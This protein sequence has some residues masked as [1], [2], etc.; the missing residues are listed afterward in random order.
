MLQV[1]STEGPGLFWP[2]VRGAV[3]YPSQFS[4]WSL[5]LPYQQIQVDPHGLNADP[6]LPRP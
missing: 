4:V 6:E 1:K 2:N 5:K 3:G